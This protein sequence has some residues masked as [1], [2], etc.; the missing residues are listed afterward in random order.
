VHCYG[1]LGSIQDAASLAFHD[2]YERRRHGTVHLV[3]LSTATVER[4]GDRPSLAAIAHISKAVDPAEPAGVSESAILHIEEA[5][6]PHRQ[7]ADSKR[8]HARKPAPNRR[9]DIG[10]DDRITPAPIVIV[11]DLL[12][13]I[14]SA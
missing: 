12:V 1:I 7:H 5:R 8:Q 4:S 10:D 11:D 13:W 9:I 2:V 6:A 3:E 14:L